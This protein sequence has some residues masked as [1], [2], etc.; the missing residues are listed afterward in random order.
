MRRSDTKDDAGYGIGA[1][2]FAFV[3]VVLAMA[4]LVVAAQAFD[5]SGEAKDAAAL[6]AGAPA[7]LTEF[8]ITPG[9]IDVA[10]GGSITVSNDGTAAHNLA[11]KGTDLR[12][13][14]LTPGTNE[15]L[16]LASLDAGM[17]TIF[18]EIPG[19][20]S[21][22]MVAMLM[23]G[24]SHSGGAGQIAADPNAGINT[25]LND[26]T[27]ER[28]AAPVKAFP[29]ATEGTGAQDLAPSV[30]PDG[31]K[32]FDLTAEIVQ[33]EV[34]PGKKVEAWTY[35]GTVPAPTIRVN[36]GDHVRMVLKNELP[37][38][39]VLH[40]HGLPDLP[41][42]MDGVPDITQPPIK[43]GES[44][45]YEFVAHGPALGMYHSHHHAAHQV[46]DGMF[47][48]I[49]VGSLPSPAGVAVSQSIPMILNDAGSIGLTLNGKSFPATAPIK[50]KLGEW[51]QIDYFTE[52]LQVHPM[53]LHGVPQ[54]VIAKDG[55]AVSA[56]Y[57]ADTVLVA[58]G[59]RYSVLVHATN[60]GVWAFHCH[61]LTH[62]ESESGMFGMVT[63][64][65]IE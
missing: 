47:G 12:T 53:H 64:F 55:F 5:R 11:V 59:E 7:S 16:D 20:A 40:L 22:G 63:A 65:I 48:A 13:P 43:P 2:T 1:W 27:D 46:P 23:V 44:F 29:A 58:P 8:A 21:S 57:L 54:L 6:G 45:T 61:I 32:Q 3:G 41:N 9:A 19:H 15:R 60:P 30:L 38:S 26:Q 28:M 52:G 42:A 49:Y 62:A 25:K 33:W 39:T 10:V 31:T 14:D 51:V 35:N 50:A 24:T 4:A 36:D 18:C 56:P 37:E 34:A 17:Y